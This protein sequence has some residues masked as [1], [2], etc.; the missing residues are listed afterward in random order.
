MQR[1]I[2]DFKRLSP[3]RNYGIVFWS[4]GT[5]WISESGSI[6]ESSSSENKM[7]TPLSFGSDGYAGKHMKITSLAKAL[8]GHSFE[9]IYFDCCHMGSVEVAY[10]LRHAT[11]NLVA[12]TTELGVEG[13]PYDLNVTPLLKGRYDQAADNTFNYY[14]RKYD[15]LDETGAPDI[16]SYGCSISTLYLPALDGLAA[17]T[18]DVFA[19]NTVLPSGYKSVQHY[20]SYVVPNGNMFDFN[21]YIKALCGDNS[22]LYSQWRTQFD[23]VVKNHN[24]T[25]RV[26]TLNASEFSGLTSNIITSQ[27]DFDLTGDKTGYRET[28]WWT[29]VVSTV[30]N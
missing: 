24:T 30:F 8:S 27:E 9:F 22:S 1:V 26:F 7:M 5:G 12:S 19:A 6:D 3:A 2:S 13:M 4:H 11:D 15:T 17:A 10:E 21:H 14:N 29:D 25:P 28:A 18:R 23:K 16:S 20:R